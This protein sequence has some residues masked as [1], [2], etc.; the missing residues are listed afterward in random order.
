[1]I[2]IRGASSA[3][4]L[5]LLALVTEPVVEIPR[6]GP[7]PM[8]ADRYLF[9]AGLLRASPMRQ[10]TAAEISEGWW[11]NAGSV[12]RACDEIIAR[13]PVARICVMGS[14]SGYAGSFDGTYAAAKAALHAYVETKALTYPG[15]QLVAIAPSIIGDAGMTLRRKDTEA[16]MRR[17][18]DHPKRRFLEAAEV[19]A[20]VHHVLYVDRGYL[21]GTVIRMHGGGHA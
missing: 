11:V 15:Q 8:N 21:S 13:N 5:A 19:A 4:A 3:I 9:T 10:Q 14:E 6:D 2:A 18:L 12:I 1:M 17:R 7:V 20:L 16:L